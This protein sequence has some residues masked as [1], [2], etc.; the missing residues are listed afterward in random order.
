MKDI[1]NRKWA[2]I[3]QINREFDELYHKIAVHFNL[4]DSSL[5]VLYILYE[6]K[7]PC[8]QKEICD[9]W[10]Y[11][12]QTINSAIKHLENVGYINKGYEENNKINK[13]IGLTPLGLEIAEK[14]VKKVI[15][16]EDRAFASINEKDLDT[17]IELMQKPLIAFKDEVNKIIK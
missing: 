7:R 5:W 16:M 12:K 10:C 15:E 2:I 6:T 1:I 9:Y 17:I 3:T 4:S 14:S 8:T 13:K 11:N